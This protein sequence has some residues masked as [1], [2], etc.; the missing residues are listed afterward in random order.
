MLE[1]ILIWPSTRADPGRVHG[2]IL[3]PGDASGSIRNV[4]GDLN[5][6][7]WRRNLEQTAIYRGA[8]N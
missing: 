5:T 4:I 7:R 2:D 8:S 6:S 1:P 3:G